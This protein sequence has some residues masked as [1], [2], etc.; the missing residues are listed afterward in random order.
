M[1][2]LEDS[3]YAGSIAADSGRGKPVALGSDYGLG[4]KIYG[5]RKRFATQKLIGITENGSPQ[6]FIVL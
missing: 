3:N 6:P 2:R 1:R 4:H 5:A